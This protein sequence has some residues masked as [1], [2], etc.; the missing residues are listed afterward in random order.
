MILEAVPNFSTAEATACDAISRAASEAGARVADVHRDARHNR[1][2]LT[3]LGPPAP[4]GAAAF[5]AARAALDRIDLTTHRGIHPRMGALDVLPF[6]PLR[7]ASMEDAVSLARAVGTR[8]AEELEL[9]VF[10]YEAA[11]TR[12][13]RRNLA[14]VRPRCFA[15]TPPLPGKPDFGPER[16]HPTGGCTA[17]GARPPLVAFNV[18]LETADVAVARAIARAV[19]ERDGGLPGVKALGLLLG[20][21]AQVSMNLCDPART[22]TGAA[23]AAVAREARAR[24][25]DVAAGEIVGLAPRAAL[26]PDPARTLKL[27]AWTPRMI[28]E[29]H[30]T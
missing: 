24:G 7:D 21:R 14:A 13:E 25:T 12:P 23:F 29:E 5:A 20:D 27:R 17:V 9:P 11:A 1:S 16:V 26:P 18:E 28:L 15:G 22:G 30:L 6:V 3:L 4:L 8:L 19:R 10:L 2:V